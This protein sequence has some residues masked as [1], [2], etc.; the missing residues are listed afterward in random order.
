MQLL[1]ILVLISIMCW[2]VFARHSLHA[3]SRWSIGVEKF[4]TTYQLSLTGQLGE[5]PALTT[6]AEHVEMQISGGVSG[7]RNTT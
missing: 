2:F 7:K 5:S 6:R 1:G 3:M 4:T